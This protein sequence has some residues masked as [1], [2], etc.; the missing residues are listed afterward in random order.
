MALMPTN[1]SQQSIGDF[2]NSLAPA[3]AIQKTMNQA[4]QVATTPTAKGSGAAA[5]TGG[6]PIDELIAGIK[7]TGD[8]LAQAGGTVAKVGGDLITQVLSLL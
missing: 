2:L 7:G 5:A 6:N 3:A 8:T 4:N 1:S